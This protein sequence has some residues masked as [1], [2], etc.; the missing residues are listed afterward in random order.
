MSKS[1]WS[2]GLFKA[3]VSLMI[4]CLNDLCIDV[5]GALKSPTIIVLLSVFPFMSVNIYFI[6]LGALML[7]A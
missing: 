3:D 6:N 5:S 1:I 4:L 7:C 2:N